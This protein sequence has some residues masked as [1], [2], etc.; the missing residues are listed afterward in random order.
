MSS[1]R[2]ELTFKLFQYFTTQI[3]FTAAP[4]AIPPQAGHGT[5]APGYNQSAQQPP[6]YQQPGKKSTLSRFCYF[7]AACLKLIKKNL[8][9]KN[10]ILFKGSHNLLHY[11]NEPR[12]HHYN[13]GRLISTLDITLDFF[14]GACFY[15]LVVN[16]TLLSLHNTTNSPSS[17]LFQLIFSAKVFIFA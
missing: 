6:N 13:R 14:F 9:L 10:S 11:G 17:C 4:S 8:P 1:Y 16:T 3:F 15:T 7:R 2:Y 12:L 5:A